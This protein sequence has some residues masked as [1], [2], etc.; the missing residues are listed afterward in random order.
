MEQSLGPACT[1]MWTIVP[2]T[3]KSFMEAI[4]KKECPI[5]PGNYPLKNFVLDTN[6]NWPLLPY[7][8]YRC[9]WRFY[10]GGELVG[11]K[12][13]LADFI[14][15]YTIDHKS[16]HGT[17]E[18]VNCL[19]LIRVLMAMD[20][21]ADM[22]V[23]SG[24]QIAFVGHITLNP[25][26]SGHRKQ[27]L[28]A[29]RSVIESYVVTMISYRAF[30]ALAAI[31]YLAHLLSAQYSKKF[32]M[33][34]AFSTFG[35]GGWSNEQMEQNMGPACTALW[36]ILP[37]TMKGLME[38]LGQKDCPIL[39]GNYTVKA[40]PLDL[41]INWPLLPYDR[42]RFEERFYLSGKLVGCKRT[43][44]NGASK[45]LVDLDQVM[46]SPPVRSRPI[47]L[48]ISLLVKK[49]AAYLDGLTLILH[50][51]NQDSALS[52]VPWS[53]LETRLGFQD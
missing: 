15:L 16:A 27:L 36:N 20:Y 6:I 8:K 24:R 2:G 32:A 9:E 34:F 23:T 3:M 5:E 25:Q 44:G 30:L 41:N 52:K 50:L 46:C 43:I 53:P 11:C 4:G 7:G 29:A 21:Q 22:V 42:Y 39:P 12:R 18:I 45:Y 51:E 33:R 26:S 47:G 14:H 1:A 49:R 17:I 35:N 48:C 38:S 19:L 13:M 31:T 40:F 28:F 10:L 37:G